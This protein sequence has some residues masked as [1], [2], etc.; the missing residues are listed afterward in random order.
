M[1]T[2][3]GGPFDEK[4]DLAEISALNPFSQHS[5][6]NKLQEQV[7]IYDYSSELFKASQVN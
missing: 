3:F 6:R 7:V 2:S 1:S 5:F 4:L